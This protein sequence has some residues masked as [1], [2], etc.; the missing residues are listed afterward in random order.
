MGSA[1]TLLVIVTA[2]IV[3]VVVFRD[4]SGTPP[5]SGNPRL[6][7]L[8]RKAQLL[9]AF[10]AVPMLLVAALIV[11]LSL[12]G[13]TALGLLPPLA[14]LAFGAL[15]AWLSARTA[16]RYPERFASQPA[17]W[18]RGLLGIV[19]F[20]AIASVMSGVD[21][22]LDL[23]RLLALPVLFAVALAGSVVTFPI[24]AW[25]VRTASRR[26]PKTS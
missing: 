9:L 22:M 16:H 3:M 25:L 6:R 11:D 5:R 8:P 20:M 12:S 17:G 21:A 10:Q 18:R 26:A 24:D 1:V 2:I 19:L 13:A 4:R 23:P 7:E 14:I 15:T